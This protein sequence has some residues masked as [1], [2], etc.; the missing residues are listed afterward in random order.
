MEA[1]DDFMVKKF[2]PGTM[3]ASYA[4]IRRFVEWLVFAKKITLEVKEQVITFN[5]YDYIYRSEIYTF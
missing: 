1:Y 5:N 3:K 4:Y 2:A